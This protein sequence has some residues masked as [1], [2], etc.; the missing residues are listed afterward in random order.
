MCNDWANWYNHHFEYLLFLCVG[1]IQSPHTLLQHSINCGTL[2]VLSSHWT[3]YLASLLTTL[4]S[5]GFPDVGN[6]CKGVLS[7]LPSSL[8]PSLPLPCT[9]GCSGN[10]A[11]SEDNLGC[12]LLPCLRQGFSVYC[13]YLWACWP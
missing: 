7:S 2:D 3:L 13:H 12:G 10:L 11:S 6:S 9:G 5:F 4:L 8:F 1:N